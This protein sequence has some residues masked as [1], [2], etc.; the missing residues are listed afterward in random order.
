MNSLETIDSQEKPENDARPKPALSDAFFAEFG[1]NSIDRATLHTSA[2][3]YARLLENH[4]DEVANLAGRRD[5]TPSF[6]FSAVTRTVSYND[7]KEMERLADPRVG[8]HNYYSK[9]E[10]EAMERSHVGWAKFYGVAGGGIVA[11]LAALPVFWGRHPAL[12]IGS[13]VLGAAAGYAAGGFLGQKSF[14]SFAND[15]N[16]LSLE[17]D[18]YGKTLGRA[19]DTNTKALGTLGILAGVGTLGLRGNPVMGVTIGLLGLGTYLTSPIVRRVGYCSAGREL[20]QE[21]ESG[22]RLGGEWRALMAK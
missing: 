19:W 18:K 2:Q 5:G 17:K 9:P 3:P 6:G 22:R 20:E 4:F 13:A 14:E 21:A 8:L 1:K 11:G 7:L 12:T 10:M 15:S 16:Y